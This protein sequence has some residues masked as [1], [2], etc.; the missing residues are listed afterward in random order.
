MAGMLLMLERDGLAKP[1]PIF[2]S[3]LYRVGLKDYA[4]RKEHPSL[5]VLV[6]AVL[7]YKMADLRRNIEHGNGML[8]ALQRGPDAS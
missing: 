4:K 3:G 1:L 5:P 6:G 8:N 2:W 7:R